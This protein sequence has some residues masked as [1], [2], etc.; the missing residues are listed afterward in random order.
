A[1]FAATGTLTPVFFQ[2][3][4][5][6]GAAGTSTT[7]PN[8]GSN[9][10]GSGI[11]ALGVPRSAPATGAPFAFSAIQAVSLA[12][13]ADSTVTGTTPAAHG[14]AVG[15]RIQIAGADTA[16]Y[17]GASVTILT[18]PTTTTFTYRAARTTTG[19]PATGFPFWL[20]VAQSA[21][22]NGVAIS[23]LTSVGTTATVT[24]QA[25]HGL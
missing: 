14:L 20:P 9:V 2:A 15:N 24:T 23:R 3:N 25:N 5:P 8:P 12:S 7:Q 16:I 10:A 6:A 13:N 22:F 21:N 4:V 19:T 11:T 17:N 1:A 18:V